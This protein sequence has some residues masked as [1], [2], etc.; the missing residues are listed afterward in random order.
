MKRMLA[1]SVLFGTVALVAGASRSSPQTVPALSVC[2]TEPKAAACT[3]V[4]GDRADGWAAQSRAEVMAP[5]GMVTTSQPLA[6]QAGLQIMMNGGNAIDAAVA[7]AAVLNLVEPMNIGVGGDLFAIIYIAKEKKLYTL[8]ASGMAPSGATLDRFNSL[9]YHSDPENWG[10]GSGMPRY[11][12]LT[13]TVPGSC[14][15][16]GGGAASAS[17]R[18]TFKEVLAAGDRLCRERLPDLAAHRQR[19]ASSQRFAAAEVLHRAGSGFGQ[20]LVHRRQAPGRGADLP[21]SRSR[22]RP[23]GCCRRAAAT[24]STKARSRARSSPSRRRSAA[25]MTMDD[26][27][28]YKGEWVEAAATNY[29]GYEVLELP[30]PSQAW[31]ANEMLNILEAC[32][33]KW[34]PGQTLASL[35]PRSPEI[36][37]PRGRSQEAR[38]SRSVRLQRRSEFRE[39]ADR[40][41]AV[42]VLR[43]ASLCE[44]GRSRQGIADRAAQQQPISPAGDTIVLSDR[45]QRRQ[46]GVLGQQQLCRFRLRHHRAGLRLHPAQPRRTVL[47][48]SRTART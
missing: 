27:A 22:A 26:L 4:R 45:R 36:L 6:A 32:V 31:A 35:G 19:L 48:R 33:P 25:R 20:D 16:L 40:A 9:G 10:P 2:N 30:P 41:A 46:H 18:K 39:G 43:R 29:H 7:T 24:P 17:A 12:I 3:A 1:W 21:Q 14:L 42:E 47:A 23:S 44:Q 38:L 13:V 11:G 37:A 15:G 5:H 8:N 34:A 28:N